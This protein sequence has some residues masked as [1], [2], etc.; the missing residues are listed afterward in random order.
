[1]CIRDSPYTGALVGDPITLPGEWV[2]D[3][4]FSE[5]EDEIYQTSRVLVVEPL[6]LTTYV[7]AIDTGDH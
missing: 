5:D 6:T 1:M 4:A 7:T 2:G 3:M